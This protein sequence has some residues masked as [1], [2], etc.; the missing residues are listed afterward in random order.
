MIFVIVSRSF[1]CFVF[2][3]VGIVTFMYHYLTY[4]LTYAVDKKHQ[5]QRRRTPASGLR[6]HPPDT[7]ESESI[8]PFDMIFGIFDTRREIFDAR[9]E[10]FDERENQM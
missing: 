3:G 4:V 9:R 10:I 7:T 1:S 6:P 2:V 8:V 5:R